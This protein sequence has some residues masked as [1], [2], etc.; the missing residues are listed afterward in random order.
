M[1]VACLEI[2]NKLYW[3]WKKKISLK[4]L[5]LSIPSY[6]QLLN[7][8]IRGTIKASEG[9][10]VEVDY[11][12]RAQGGFAITECIASLYI[13]TIYRFLSTYKKYNKKGSS[14]RKSYLLCT[15]KNDAFQGW[16]EDNYHSSSYH[17]S[18]L[19]TS[20][21]TYNCNIRYLK[22]TYVICT[23]LAWVCTLS[24]YNS[25]WLCTWF[26]QYLVWCS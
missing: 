15:T 5:N 19:Y 10:A 13:A 16:S 2:P 21:D 18:D 1:P 9:T 25:I 6:T 11:I 8:R 20:A 24:Q 14:C 26:R 7:D 4:S 3:L 22:A 12:K 23:I 17:S